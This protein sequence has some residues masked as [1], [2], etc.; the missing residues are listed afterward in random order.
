MVKTVVAN[1]LN[2][3]KGTGNLLSFIHHPLSIFLLLVFSSCQQK[4]KD[5]RK[6]DMHVTFSPTDKNPLGTYVANQLLKQKFS[7]Y[8]IEK[9]NKPFNEFFKD[10]TRYDLTR[11]GNVYCV[12]AQQFYP[13]DDDVEAISEFVSNGNTIFVAANYFDTAFLNKFHLK[14]EGDAPIAFQMAYGTDMGQTGVRM[15]DSTQFNTTLYSY[16]FFPFNIELTRADSY[17]SKTISQTADGRSSGL[18]FNYGNGRVIVAANAAALTNYFLLTGINYKY[19][20]N[21]L[22]YTPEK[23]NS[24][25]GDDGK[26]ISTT[27]I[28][29]DTYYNTLGARRNSD[30]ALSQLLKKPALAWAFW[31]LLLLAAFWIYNGLI[32]RQRIIEVIKPNTNS[33][34]EFAET[35]ARLYLLKKDN[36][37][38]ALKMIT[39]FLE[40]VRNKYYLNTST[41]NKEFA[42]ALT[43]K[44]GQPI[45]RSETLLLTI[46][47]IQSQDSIGDHA[48]LDLNTQLQRFLK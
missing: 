44:T 5:D 10:Y 6:V 46:A 24:L 42:E 16:Y 3:L 15:S 35:V 28:T 34:V 2:I 31:L 33:S 25:K 13:N 36:K 30:G 1:A 32:R 43:A 41:L 38:I 45:E 47:N 48:L 21:L 37:N 7:G 11:N 17:T 12:I 9:S 23:E 18:V 39:Y 22:A 27:G 14:I 8:D 40:Q 4:E 20:Q 29:V 19:L 26:T